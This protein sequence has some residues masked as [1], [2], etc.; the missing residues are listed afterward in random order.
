MH[1]SAPHAC[2]VLERPERAMDALELELRM[3]VNQHAG[4]GG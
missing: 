2:L 4:G 1:V 3:V